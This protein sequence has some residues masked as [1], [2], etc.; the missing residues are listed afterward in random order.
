M[1]FAQVALGT[2]AG[3][4]SVANPWWNPSSRALPVSFAKAVSGKP[5]LKLGGKWLPSR[6]DEAFFKPKRK[7]SAMPSQQSK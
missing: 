5:L 1:K 6:A 2:L 7:G 4:W 3:L